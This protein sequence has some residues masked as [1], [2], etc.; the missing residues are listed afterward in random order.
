[1]ADHSVTA[2]AGK[3]GFL[4]GAGGRLGAAL[5]AHYRDSGLW[6][7]RAL[8]SY[9]DEAVRAVPER[10]AAV[11]LDATGKSVRSMTYAELDDLSRRVCAGLHTLGVRAGDTVSV[12]IP[13]CAEFSA[14]AFGITRLGAVYSGIPITYGRHE[15][16]FML[17]RARTKV[18]FIAAALGRHDLVELARQARAANP[19]VQHVVVLGGGAPSETGWIGFDA[20]VDTEPLAE[21]PV[22]DP[23]TIAFLGFTSGTT[24]EPKAAVHLHQ[25]VDTIVREW[26]RHL[27][28]GAL[29][30][31]LINLVM[32]P[33]GH[34][35]GFYW[36]AMMSTLL[37]GTAVYLE[38]WS[39]EAG[40]RAL[41]EQ[42]VTA[43]VGSPTFL[44][45]ILALPGARA[46]DVPALSLVSIP[47]APIP[48]GLVPRAR[49]QL[50]CLVVP[51]WGMTEYGI[52]VSGSPALPRE[53]ME[54]T[55]GIPI[56][57]CEARVCDAGDTPLPDGVEG[58]LQV[59][60][61]GLFVGYLDRP[62]FTAE[63]FTADGW[64]RTGDRAVID[65]DGFV[66]LSGRTKDIVIRGGEN[67]PVVA[68]ESLLYQHPDVT[69]AAVIGIPDERLGERAHAVVSLRSKGTMSL[70]AIREFLL[71]KGLSR[72]FLPEGITTLE[73]IPKTATGKIRKVE[74][75]AL[76]SPDATTETRAADPG[77]A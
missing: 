42:A 65:T 38:R 51:S 33:V 4:S 16:Q 53:R 24:N 41:R 22:V 19:G 44:Q 69:D 71:A 27:G 11:S 39:P 45:D 63:A 77:G 6:R 34:G 12:M 8:G 74:L 14:I 54:A 17:A 67:V 26:P 64:F 76:M 36:G 46:E 28:P 70:D 40:L 20:L 3:P 73:A 57:S 18:L 60:G 21:L 62:D 30:D 35:T 5:I 55:D 66:S 68:I 29:G 25:T 61:P 47:G 59:R 72:R 56:G 31:P 37:Q 1:M 2:R 15:V 13:N 32:S 10:T 7:D 50:G 48:R 43:M 23:T 58:D 52:G 9:L 49:R 75:K